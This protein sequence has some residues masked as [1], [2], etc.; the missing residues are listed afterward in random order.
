[1]ELCIAIK[2]CLGAGG[3]YNCLASW[4]VGEPA[5]VTAPATITLSAGEDCRRPL[6]SLA[7][8][9]APGSLSATASAGVLHY[10]RLADATLWPLPD[11]APALAFD[12]GDAYVA[13]SPGALRV[14]GR[15]IAQFLH[16]RDDFNAERLAEGLLELLRQEP[17]GGDLAA[18]VTVVVVE[19]R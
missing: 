6:L 2:T 4:A 11:E 10:F 19:A 14:N 7:L 3:D 17:G 9:P 8:D 15:A 13:V 12:R 1:M 16:V 18:D 5:R